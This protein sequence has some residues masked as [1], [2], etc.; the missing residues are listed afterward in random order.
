[1]EV[2]GGMGVFMAVFLL[3]CFDNTAA[4]L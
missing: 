2:W 1:V 3:P 4:L